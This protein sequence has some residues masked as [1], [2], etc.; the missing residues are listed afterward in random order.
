M[1]FRNPPKYLLIFYTMDNDIYGDFKPTIRSSIPFFTK[2][3]AEKYLE[4]FISNAEG[5]Y[6]K[7]L[8]AIIPA[9]ECVQ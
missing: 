3:D 5:K 4:K 9:L 6:I 8:T 7:E 2:E 1:N